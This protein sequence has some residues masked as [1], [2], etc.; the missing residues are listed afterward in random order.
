MLLAY[1]IAMSLVLIYYIIK[2]F[3]S[4]QKEIELKSFNRPVE[5]TPKEIQETKE[6]TKELKEQ[7][8]E[9]AFILLPHK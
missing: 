5:V 3:F 8:S 1:I 6:N 7:N 9:K 2:I 4:E